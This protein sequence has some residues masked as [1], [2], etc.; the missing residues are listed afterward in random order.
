MNKVAIF[1]GTTI[2]CLSLILAACN[3]SNG[4]TTPVVVGGEPGTVGCTVTA[5]STLTGFNYSPEKCEIKAGQK[6]TVI[7][8]GFHPLIGVKG[9]GGPIDETKTTVPI[10]ATITTV[11]VT[12]PTAGVFGFRCDNHSSMLGTVTVTN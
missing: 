10:D 1:G 9:K 11:T 2:L 8:T 4:G 12:Y 6:V 7:S 3:S 5:I